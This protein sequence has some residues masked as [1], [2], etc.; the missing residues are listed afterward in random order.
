LRLNKYIWSLYKNSSEGSNFINKW[1]S[2]NIFPNNEYSKECN[3]STLD[4]LIQ[5]NLDNYVIDN[6]VNWNRFFRDYFLK[7]DFIF[8]ET[9]NT[10]LKWIS[11]GVFINDYVLV[12][13]NNFQFWTTQIKYISN[14]LYSVFPEYFFPYLLDCEFNKFQNICNEF[15]IPISEVPKKNNWENRASFYIDLC[16]ALYEFRMIN[17]LTPSELCAF[18]YDFAPNYLNEIEDFELPSPSK[19]WF[20]GGDKRHFTFLDNATENTIDSWQGNIDAK[21]GDIV[22]LY[23]LTPRSYIHSIW[24]VVKDGFV[25]PFFNYYSVLYLSKPI[26]LEV[27]ITIN[28]LKNN[29]IWLNN[30]LVR[31]NLQ[32]I[33]GYPIKYLEYIELLSILKLKGQNIDNLPVIKPTN[34]LNTDDLKNERDV[35]IQLIEPFLKLLKYNPNDWIRQMSIKMGR[36]ERN[37]PD[38][39]FGANPKRGEETAKMIIESKYKIKTKKEL[40]ETYFQAKS[41]AIRLQATK[42]IIA[43]SEGIWIYQSKLMSYK[44]D[45]YF[46]CNWVDIENPDVLQKIQKMIGKQ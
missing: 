10:Y 12:E 44:F 17:N 1:A 36:G 35:E 14:I 21:K 2:T 37:Y 29:P 16:N 4:K 20:V 31:K 27:H 22:V 41:Y 23:C 6:K 43:A 28:D 19:V 15:N 7:N 9:R 32:G 38:Y 39:C 46:N 13:K 5:N 8:E 11:E 33:N 45:E 25:D 34:R 42:F 18:L 40:Q 26:K 30:P 3:T 24:R